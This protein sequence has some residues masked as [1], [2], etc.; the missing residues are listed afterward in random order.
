MA[1]GSSSAAQQGPADSH[2]PTDRKAAAKK[3]AAR[4][5]LRTIAP[6]DG[7]PDLADYQYN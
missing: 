2:T 7:P 4:T 5:R 6:N 3:I 1:C